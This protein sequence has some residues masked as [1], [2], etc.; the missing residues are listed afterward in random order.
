MKL[1]ACALILAMSAFAADVTGKWSGSF[2]REGAE[3]SSA[4][5]ILKQSGTELTGSGGPDESQ[6]WPMSKGKIVGNKITGEV[7]E[8]GGA[9]Y[10]LDLTLEGDHI[11][12]TVTATAPSGES[13]KGTLDAT[14]QK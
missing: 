9:L 14:R 2:N 12:G 13:V 11:K 6:Q 10:K 3:P 8:P 5:I 1:F 7:Q 4:Y